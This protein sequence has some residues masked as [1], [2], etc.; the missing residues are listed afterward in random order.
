MIG[1]G[2]GKG[3]SLPLILRFMIAAVMFAVSAVL[4]M[5]LGVQRALQ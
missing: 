1:Y 2:F 5:G 3:T 4:Q